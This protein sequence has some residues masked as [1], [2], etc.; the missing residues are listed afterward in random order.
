M[1][2]HPAPST[3]SKNG[4]RLTNYGSLLSFAA[5]QMW[6]RSPCDPHGQPYDPGYFTNPKRLEGFE[7]TLKRSGRTVLLRLANLHRCYSCDEPV[8]PLADGDHVIP[9]CEGGPDGIQNFAPMC[10]YCNSRKGK[11]DL[12]YWW[13]AKKGKTLLDLN[14]DVIVVYVRGKYTQLLER[15]TLEEQPDAATELLLGHFATTLPTLAHRDA[16]KAIPARAGLVGIS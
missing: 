13:W 10:P 8:N 2:A 1:V 6:M 14:P 12:M 4:V 9:K 3:S 5:A 11:F 7:K 16:F 15:G